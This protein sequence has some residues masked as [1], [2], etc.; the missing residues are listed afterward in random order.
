MSHQHVVIRDSLQN[1]TANSS[2]VRVNNNISMRMSP[3]DKIFQTQA[4]YDNK[5]NQV[6]PEKLKIQQLQ[7]KL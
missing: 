4:A 5:A 1:E 3:N 7:K 6:S 2:I